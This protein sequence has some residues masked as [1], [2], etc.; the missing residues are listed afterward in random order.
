MS[1]SVTLITEHNKLYL[2]DHITK[3]KINIDFIKLIKSKRGKNFKNEA[4]IKAIG[5]FSADKII[6]DLTAGLGRDSIIMALQG[7]QI[8][9]FEQNQLIYQ[10]LKAALAELANSEYQ[11]IADKITLKNQDSFSYCA[12]LTYDRNNI[13]YLDPMFPERSKTAKVKK[14]LQLLQ[15]ICPVE[16]NLE[17]LLNC[18]KT[19]GKT[20]LKRPRFAAKLALKEHHIIKGSKI[21]FYV[22]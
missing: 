20:I 1:D 12:N 5:K 18:V 22:Y 2:Y 15:K 9:M 7:Y 10:M 16:K 14:Q 4:L 11:Y 3:L 17:H 21:D 13:F 6:H 8:I 19:K